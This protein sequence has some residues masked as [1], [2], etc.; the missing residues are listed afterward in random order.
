[1]PLS[2]LL[3]T[4]LTIASQNFHPKSVENMKRTVTNLLRPN[5][6]A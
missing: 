6:K 2:T 4:E 1:M 5:V 3:F